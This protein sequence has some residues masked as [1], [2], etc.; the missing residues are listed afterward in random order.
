[1]AVSEP[2]PGDF[3]VFEELD[4][5]LVEEAIA[6]IMEAERKEECRALLGIGNFLFETPDSIATEFSHRTRHWGREKEVVERKD[7]PTENPEFKVIVDDHLPPGVVTW[8]RVFLHDRYDPSQ[9]GAPYDEVR[10][11]PRTW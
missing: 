8:T 6:K 4:A 2:Q 11:N 5:G 7:F 10:Y 1:M 9:D 3:P